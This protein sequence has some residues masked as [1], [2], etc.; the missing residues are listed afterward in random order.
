MVNAK[1]RADRD[2]IDAVEQR[3]I[4][5]AQ[6]HRHIRRFPPQRVKHRRLLARVGD[7]HVSAVLLQPQGKRASGQAETKD[8][9]VLAAVVHQRS[10]S[11]ESPTST[12]SMVMIHARITT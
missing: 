1:A 8:K 12:R 6:A 4:P 5:L 11:E 2:E 10:F 9:D 7:L 3:L